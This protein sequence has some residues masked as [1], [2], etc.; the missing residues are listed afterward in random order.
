MEKNIY[1]TAKSEKKKKARNG[2]WLIIAF[3]IIFITV[4]FRYAQSNERRIISPSLPEREEAYNVA[5]NFLRDEFQSSQR[6]SFPDDGFSYGKK[7]DS[8]YVIKSEYEQGL[9]GGGVKKASFSVIMRFKGG[10]T[11]D[12]NSWDVLSINKE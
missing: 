2:V 6:V 7:N 11:V 8:V 5:K 10:N 3:A 12:K 1:L 4:V 9:D